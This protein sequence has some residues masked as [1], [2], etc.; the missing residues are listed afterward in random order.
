MS[1]I[2]LF[3]VLICEA[4]IKSGE[5]NQSFGFFSE[6]FLLQFAAQM[7]KV[8]KIDELVRASSIETDA[9]QNILIFWK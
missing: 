7:N 6:N 8:W 3:K 4:N 5:T 2:L 9:I 1:D